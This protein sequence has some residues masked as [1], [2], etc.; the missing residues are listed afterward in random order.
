MSRAFFFICVVFLGVSPISKDNIM[1]LLLPVLISGLL[2][3][4]LLS[5]D[6]RS[7]WQELSGVLPISR[8]QLVSVKYLMGLILMGSFLV[9]TA[10]L[11]LIVGRYPA[12]ELVA[13]LGG[14]FGL[15]LLV[16]AV[17]LPM[18][19]KFGVEKGRIWYIVTLFLVAGASA[20]SAGIATDFMQSDVAGAL[21]W[22][23]PVVGAVLFA[24]SWLLSIRFYEKREF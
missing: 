12:Q 3:T 16:S 4:T 1:S 19:F 11:H 10:A 2:P 23:V 24:L 8:S 5:Y 6:E 17:N 20:F 13:L 14:I 18:M 9:L 22:I 7:K 21:G 15:A